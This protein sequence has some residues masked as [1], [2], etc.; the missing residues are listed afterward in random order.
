MIM[1]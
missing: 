1:S